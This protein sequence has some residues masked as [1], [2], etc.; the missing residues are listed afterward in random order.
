VALQ[1]KR[2]EDAD[3]YGRQALELF[4]Q[5]RHEVHIANALAI[6][7]SAAQQRGQS[8]KA[9]RFFAESVEMQRK[10]GNQLYL[11]SRLLEWGQAALALNDLATA[12]TALVEAVREAHASQMTAFALSAFALLAKIFERHGQ[13]AKAVQLAAFVAEHEAAVLETKEKAAEVLTAVASHL[14]AAQ[15]RDAQEYGRHASF[16]DFLPLFI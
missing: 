14:P 1:E 16:S 9:H 13:R 15:F 11:V 7:G 3:K 12:E 8:E 5:T 10:A 2:L 6:L 4:R